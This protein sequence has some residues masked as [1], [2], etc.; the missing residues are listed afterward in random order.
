MCIRSARK[1]VETGENR[2]SSVA[3]AHERISVFENM[4]ICACIYNGVKSV[5]P[6]V[7]AVYKKGGNRVV[8]MRF[9]GF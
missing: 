2:I 9:H 8:A 1:R 3:R 5:S 7:I 4:Y 6:V